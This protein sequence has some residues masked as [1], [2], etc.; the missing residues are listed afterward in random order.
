[1]IKRK[2]NSDIQ[3][4]HFFYVKISRNQDDWGF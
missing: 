2:D 3:E 4:Y 1:M